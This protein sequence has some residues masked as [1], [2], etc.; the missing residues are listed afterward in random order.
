MPITASG[1]GGRL[2]SGARGEMQMSPLA[3]RQTPD[4]HLPLRH[5]MVGAGALLLA[6]V[7]L[8]ATAPAV[9]ADPFTTRGLALTHVLTLGWITLTIMG[10]T[11]QLL[12][13]VLGAPIWSERI[14]HAAFWLFV[15]GVLA[16]VVGFWVFWPPLLVA[17]GA[18]VVGGLAGYAYNVIRTLARAPVRGLPGPYFAAATT[19]LA[20]VGLYGLTL[21]CDILHPFLSQGPVSH[22]AVHVLLGV[23]GWITLLAM[24][25]AY[26]LVPMFALAHGRGAGWGRAVLGLVGGGLLLVLAVLTVDPTRP[27]VEAAGVVPLA[28]ILLFVVDQGLYLRARGRR[29]DLSLRFTV[30]ALAYLAAAALMT[31]MDV[32]GWLPVPPAVLVELALL[33]WAGCLINGQLYKI[34]P[35]LVWYDRYAHVAGTAPV[36]LLREMYDARSGEANLWTVAAAPALLALG[37]ATARPGLA[38][39]GAVALLAGAALLLTNLVRVVRRRSGPGPAGAVHRLAAASR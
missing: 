18:L 28:G 10:A 25:V 7:L 14:A 23:L 5:L 24:G 32:A 13:V 39:A 19:F 1:P 27:A 26:K 36:P 4:V 21:A 12:P 20:A 38:E 2:A 8:V 3:S 11:Y 29:L 9:L 37:A 6:A 30:A 31:W 33:G 35:F 15:P 16:L 22:I 17:G 34:V